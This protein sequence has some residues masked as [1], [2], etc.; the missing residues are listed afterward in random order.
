MNRRGF[1]LGAPALIA[2]T[3]LMAMPRNP[4]RLLRITP[5]GIYRVL[6]TV[7]S[8]RMTLVGFRG[9]D[10]HVLCSLETDARFR[11]GDLV[12]LEG[13]EHAGVIPEPEFMTLSKR[14]KEESMWR[15]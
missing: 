1:L 6:R 15:G 4:A 10:T 11:A 14:I 8:K 2:S 13:H 12:Q 7:E 9:C 3:Q 5:T